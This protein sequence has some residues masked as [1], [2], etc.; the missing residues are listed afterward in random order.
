MSRPRSND[1]IGFAP[2][3]IT[4]ADVAAVSAV[5]RGGWI[6]TGEECIA[7]E[8]ELASYIGAPHMIAVSSGTAA[9]EIALGSLELQPGSRVGVP[10]WTFAATGL[11]A[12]R[13]GTSVVLLDSEPDTLNVSPASLAAALDAGLDA[14]VPVH[15]GGVPVAREVRDLCAAAG[16]PAV[17]DAAHALGATDDRGRV[18]GHGTAAA[19]FSFYATKNITCA[20]GGAIAVES[21]ERA[22]YMRAARLHGFDADAWDRYRPEGSDVEYDVVVP[23]IKANLPDLLAALARSQLA[24]ID[25]LQARRRVLTERYRTN[26]ARV[27]TLRF[28]PAAPVAGSADHLAVIALSD[29]RQR[30]AIR[31]GLAKAGIA[32]SV[33]FRPLHQLSWFREHAQAGPSGVATADD[34]ADRVLS[35]PLS[36][37]L[38]TDDVDRV[39]EVLCDLLHP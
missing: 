16:V 31:A 26:L 29:Q 6:T 36:P 7:L 23:G 38:S 9:L 34:H 19:C 4:D 21:A 28:V 1:A 39:C 22:G 11:A 25:D 14:V 24:R 37:A 20:E 30:P 15:F 17:E 32:S 5:L 2:P 18:G 10:T 12:H 33:H 35:L 27:E 3:D 13:V 8:R